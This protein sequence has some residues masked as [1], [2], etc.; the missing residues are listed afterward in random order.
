MRSK[1]CQQDSSRKK[2]KSHR[3]LATTR[4][5]SGTQVGA[6]SRDHPRATSPLGRRWRTGRSHL[7][8]TSSGGGELHCRC[9]R[10]HA[11]GCWTGASLGGVALLLT[12]PL[13]SLAKANCTVDA[14]AHAF[15]CF[16]RLTPAAPAPRR[17]CGC[18]GPPKG[19]PAP[20]PLSVGKTPVAGAFFRNSASRSPDKLSH[21]GWLMIIHISLPRSGRC[22]L[23]WEWEQPSG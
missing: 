13:A 8:F 4:V 19:P 18:G 16:E 15:L 14:L 20:Q 17:R 11:H 21:P 22:D 10:P 6:R 2:C 23:P 5:R 9:T 1:T 3:E 12:P 7:L